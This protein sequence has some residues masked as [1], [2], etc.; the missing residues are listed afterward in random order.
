MMIPQKLG[1]RVMEDA[2]AISEVPGAAAQAGATTRL[3]RICPR[4]VIHGLAS[5]QL[6]I[7]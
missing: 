4:V 1:S 7:L 2:L 5:L 6:H 3:I